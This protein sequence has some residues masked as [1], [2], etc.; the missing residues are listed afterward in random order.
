MLA[1]ACSN[2][3]SNF[4][5]TVS[6]VNFPNGAFTING[7][8][9]NYL[10]LNIGMAPNLHGQ[11]LLAGGIS[12]DRVLINMFGGNYTTHM[13]GSTL[14][15]NT[16]GLSTDGIFLDRN[17][18]TSAVSTHI[19]GRFS[20]VTSRISNSSLVAISRPLLRQCQTLVRPLLLMGLGLVFLAGLPA[21]AARVKLPPM[22]A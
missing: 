13:G 9:S 15:V 20:M 19:Q 18:Q 1:L 7:S 22:K 2:G 16:N 11:I 4:V 21:S 10:V 17:G 12:S 14:D 3:G 8:A 5:F 6:S